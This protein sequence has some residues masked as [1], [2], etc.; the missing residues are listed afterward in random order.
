M[1]KLIVTLF[2]LLFI[3]CT[4]KEHYTFS[5]AELSGKIMEKYCALGASTASLTWQA[6]VAKNIALE[7]KCYAIGS[8]RWSHTKLSA[9]DYSNN[10][11]DNIANKVM[12]NELARLLKDKNDTGYYP[13]LI[14]IMCGLN[15]AAASS[16]ISITLGN[17]EDAMAFDMSNIAIED[18]FGKEKY[19]GMRETVYG[20]T[21]FVLENL[22]RN[23]PKSMIIILTPQQCNN[24]NYNYKNVLEVNNALQKIAERYSVQM[25]DIFKESGITDAGGLIS[26]YIGDGIHPN[27]E[28]EKL[29][30]NFLIKRLRYIYFEK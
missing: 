15:D 21:R 18:W 12:T 9:L 26:Q 19:K 13:N 6:E 11:S 14:A 23:F 20:S 10:A 7:Y 29:L 22:I 8:T 1:R 24:G 2:V 28:G 27:A 17:Y 30:T 4:K 5:Q 25:I 16:D 3:S